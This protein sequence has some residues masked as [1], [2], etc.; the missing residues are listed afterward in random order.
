MSTSVGETL[1]AESTSSNS[2][3][4]RYKTKT[5]SDMEYEEISNIS[6]NHYTIRGLKAYTV[7]LFYIIAVNNIGR[8]PPSAPVEVRTKFTVCFDIASRVQF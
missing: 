5:S 8:G 4:V 1:T 3:I 2:F 6:A 7:Y